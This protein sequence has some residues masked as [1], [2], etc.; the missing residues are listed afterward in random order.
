M[1]FPSPKSCRQ[2]LI[3]WP[4]YSVEAAKP[5]GKRHLSHMRRA[6]PDKRGHAFACRGAVSPA[7]EGAAVGIAADV[8]EKGVGAL[9][10]PFGAGLKTQA[11]APHL[12]YLE[13]QK[14]DFLMSGNA[15][16]ICSVCAH[17]A[18]SEI[19]AAIVGGV[20]TVSDLAR[21][22]GMS[23]Q[24][25][26]RHRDNHMVADIKAAIA[27]QAEDGA[28]ERGGSILDQM[29]ALTAE[30]R[31]VLRKAK[32]T[33]DLRLIMGAIERVG[34]MLER[35]A[36]LEGLIGNGD[37]TNINI[38]HNDFRQLQVNI[39]AALEPFPDAKRAVLAALGGPTIDG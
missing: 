8:A 24:A 15:G 21:T 20:R 7:K 10:K 23:R 6:P 5:T 36:K 18:R 2:N 32:G 33:N 17:T 3:C 13:N 35:Q 14:R 28:L 1:S 19:D 29:L 39:V 38:T 9:Q 31:D 16:P 4:G 30:A 27:R 25:I 11:V 37:V 12:R 22:Y 34:V 26:M